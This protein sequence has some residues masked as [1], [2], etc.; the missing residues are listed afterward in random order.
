ML[1]YFKE[2]MVEV[3]KLNFRGAK[4]EVR[5]KLIEEPQPSIGNR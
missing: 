2:G 3:S 1:R 5:S 4:E